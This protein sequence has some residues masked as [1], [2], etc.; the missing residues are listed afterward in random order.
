MK[1]LSDR[2]LATEL[3]ALRPQPAP[4]FV[5]KLDARVAAGFEDGDARANAFDRLLTWL[6]PTR[7][8]LL[9]ASAA[10]G[11]AAVALA[12]VVVAI[13]LNGDGQTRLL[14]DSE[15]SGT[16]A[17]SK[18][19]HDSGVQFSDTPP[20]ATPERA[21][22]ASST[23]SSTAPPAQNGPYAAQARDREVERSASIVLSTEPS[24]VRRASGEIFAAIHAV[25]G[26]VLRS[27]IEDGSE[28]GGAS[29]ELL[30]PSGRLGD[31]LASFSEIAEVAS[32]Q[33][34]TADVTA[35]TV[36]L[37]ERLQD[38][39]ATVDSLLAQLAAAET[40]AE[41]AAAEA[42]L[43]AERRHVAAL[44][45]QLSDLRRRT[46]FAHV[47]LRITTSESGSPSSDEDGSWGVGSAL[48]DAGRILDVAAGVALVGL[49]V[50]APIALIVLLARLARRRWLNASRQRALN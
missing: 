4:E 9:T 40:E 13:G 41:R 7:R 35:R 2:D 36:G 15:P 1:P 5:T 42:E 32:R 18:S 25:D 43:R 19:T 50:L 45:S 27:S 49:A 14:I 33:E 17:E 6:R 31:A 39:Q 20:I 44:R 11:I 21:G 26:I 38:A 37:E 22:G 48:D 29:F 47:S 10:G 28:G 46:N 8:R 34:S 3:R 23:Q 12:T 24:E 30:V 16:A